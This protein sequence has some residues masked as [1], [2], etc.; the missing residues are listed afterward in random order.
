[1]GIAIRNIIR[2]GINTINPDI[3]IVIL[4][5]NGFTVLPGGIQAPGYLPAIDAIA[6]LQ[7]IPSEELKH[8]N[9]YNSASVY[10]DLYIDGDFHSLNRADEKGGD[11]IYFDGFEWLVI[12]RPE[13]FSLTSNWTKVR[14][15]QQKKEV[16]PVIP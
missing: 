15:I 14:V 1:M 3:S 8:I 9:N 16:A 10:Y 7:P 12:S 11:L 5:S 4:Q 6:Q 2:A 13:A